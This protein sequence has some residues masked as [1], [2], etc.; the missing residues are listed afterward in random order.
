MR[1]DRPARGTSLLLAIAVG[2]ALT[3]AGCGGGDG[4][5]VKISD[6]AQKKTQDML[7]GMMEKMKAQHKAD[8]KSAKKGR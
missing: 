7:G 6:E 5:T 2:V 4:E 3:I 1:I 8:L